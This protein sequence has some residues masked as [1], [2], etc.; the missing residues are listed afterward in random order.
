M[1]KLYYTPPSDEEFEDVKKCALEIWYSYEEPYRTEK[2]E[3]VK[4]IGNIGDN[5]MYIVAMFDLS[6]QWK[7][8]TMLQTD[9]KKALRDRMLDGGIE[10][11]MIPF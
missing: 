3:R 2:I 11:S 4:D 10:E 9:T 7:L 6:N 1:T 5:F 8:A